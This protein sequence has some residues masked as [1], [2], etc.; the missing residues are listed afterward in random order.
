MSDVCSRWT[1]CV[2]W[3]RQE[4]SGWRQGPW[5]KRHSRKRCYALGLTELLVLSAGCCFAGS[6]FC[7]L[8]F[9]R[10]CRWQAVIVFALLQQPILKPDVVFFR[11]SLP[12][13]FSSNI[14]ADTGEADCL[15]VIGTSMV[16]RPVSQIPTMV[17]PGVETVLINREAVVSPS[18]CCNSLSFV[19]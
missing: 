13:E 12:V 3:R 7:C 6:L 4:A 14:T 15:I 11:E 16:V 2:R 17:T 10:A 18:L 8:P 1:E 19:H 5:W 9:V